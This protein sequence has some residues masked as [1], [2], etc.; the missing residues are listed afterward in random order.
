MPEFTIV[1]GPNGAG[2]SSFSHLY[3]DI[4]T[5]I[6]DPD[7]FS[8]FL[9]KKFATVNLPQQ[10]IDEHVSAEYE[11]LETDAL[12][13]NQSLLVETNLRTDYLIQRGL[14]LR[15]HGYLI[16][17]IFVAL[18]DITVS[19][20]RVNARVEDKGHWVNPEA[21]EQNFI[22][23]LKN[24]KDH[25][26][27][28]DRVMII[29]PDIKKI[30]T[31]FHIPTPLLTINLGTITLHEEYDEPWANELVSEIISLIKR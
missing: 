30:D 17:F 11:R 20:E 9:Q 22:H 26:N 4:G 23:G 2:K 8:A 18:K 25:V 24:F 19:T 12:A 29:T 13:T 1:A 14:H 16:N 6:Y 15:K 10:T 7:K 3:A 5:I 21:L 28:F 27:T 31:D